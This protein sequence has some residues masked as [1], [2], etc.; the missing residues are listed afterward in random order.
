MQS[1]RFSDGFG[2]TS[3]LLTGPAFVYNNL[4]LDAVLF[5]SLINSLTEEPKAALS[6]PSIGC[7]HI[8]SLIKDGG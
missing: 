8:F 5:N 3:A 2:R 6:G 4:I 1:C 7:N